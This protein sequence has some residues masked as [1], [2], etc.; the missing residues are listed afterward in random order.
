M[1]PH[2]LGLAVFAEK[3][4]SL[5]S[6][7]GGQNCQTGWSPLISNK[8]LNNHKLQLV[9]AAKRLQSEILVPSLAAGDC[10]LIVNDNA[11]MFIVK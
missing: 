9:F 7:V 11:S 10:S 3:N 4:A 2:Q 8:N 5:M 1:G 6:G